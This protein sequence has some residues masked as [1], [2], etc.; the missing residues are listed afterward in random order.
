MSGQPVCLIAQL[1]DG[2][3]FA[4]DRYAGLCGCDTKTCGPQRLNMGTFVVVRNGKLFL[5]GCDPSPDTHP[6]AGPCEEM[7]PF[8][9]VWCDDCYPEA[10]A[11]AFKMLAKNWYAVPD[12]T[13]PRGFGKS[14]SMS[15]IG[16]AKRRRLVQYE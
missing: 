2:D 13:I 4:L 10:H 9:E 15:G 3:F 1:P 11:L 16:G 5:P 6:C 8:N 12:S 7:L 14:E